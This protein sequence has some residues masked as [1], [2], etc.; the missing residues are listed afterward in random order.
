MKTND[1]K[2]KKGLFFILIICSTALAFS[3]EGCTLFNND[4]Q[5]KNQ[6]KKLKTPEVEKEPL[7]FQE[8]EWLAFKEE[9][10]ASLRFNW[11]HILQLKSRLRKNGG[12]KEAIIR[13]DSLERIHENLEYRFDHYNSKGLHN[14]DTF[15]RN[16]NKDMRE[17]TKSLNHF[18]DK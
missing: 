4:K 14:F 6:K 7:T 10:E 5:Q 18:N 12:T 3:F 11:A 15:R 1:K 13:L 8:E 2:M 17:L 9:M 16:Y